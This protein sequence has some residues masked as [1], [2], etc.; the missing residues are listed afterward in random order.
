[1]FTTKLEGR[2]ILCDTLHTNRRLCCDTSLYKIVW[3]DRGSLNMV[4]DGVDTT[5][6]QGTL[7]TLSPVQHIEITDHNCHYGALLFDSNF[8]CIYGHDEEVSCNGVLFYGGSETR[9][10]NLDQHQMGTLFSIVTEMENEYSNIDNLREEM[11]RIALKRLVITCTRIARQ[12][13]GANG[14]SEPSFDLIRRYYV[15]VDNNFRRTRRVSDYAAMLNRTPKTITNLFAAAGLPS[16]LT[17]IHQRTVVEA[18]RLLLYSERSAKE[19]AALL[20]FDDLPSFSR[21]FKTQTSMSVSEFR[22]LHSQPMPQQSD[23]NIK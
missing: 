12:T 3:V 17:V 11:L 4:I 18:Q 16:P 8:Y 19:T 22:K 2:I 14:G 6:E 20:G 1:M 5:V 23:N 7:L 10:L 9:M 13:H 21:F 15:L